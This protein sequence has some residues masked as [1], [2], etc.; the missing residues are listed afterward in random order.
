MSD[1]L[2]VV[3]KDKKKINVDFDEKDFFDVSHENGDNV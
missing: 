2:V 1:L 3:G